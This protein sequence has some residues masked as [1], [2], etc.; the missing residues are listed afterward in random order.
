MHGVLVDGGVALHERVD[1]GDGDEDLHAA[2]LGAGW[3]RD[4]ELIQVARVVVV[5]RTPGE[6]AE[7][8][9]A[10]AAR[11]AGQLSDLRARRSRSR[12]RSHGRAS[13]AAR[14]A[15]GRHVMT[16]H[17]CNSVLIGRSADAREEPCTVAACPSTA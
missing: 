2:P 1:V 3:L 17:N 5:D 12:V 13:P 6:V 7:I 4:R 14:S 11:G 10:V 16:S 9:A 8:A 15:E